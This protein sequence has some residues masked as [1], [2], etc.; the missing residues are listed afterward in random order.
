[1]YNA[2]EKQPSLHT[3]L[4]VIYYLFLFFAF[5]YNYIF[6]NN[7]S[8]GILD[9]LCTNPLAQSPGQVKIIKI[10]LNK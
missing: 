2:H 4:L 1:M 9:L 6:S 5:Q 3:K 7:N 8:H 10:C